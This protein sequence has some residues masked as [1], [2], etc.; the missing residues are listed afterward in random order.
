MEFLKGEER[1]FF[2]DSGTSPTI[3]DLQKR[4]ANFK[5]INSK[6]RSKNPKILE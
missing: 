4:M 2:Y 6:S 3:F 1:K 5:I